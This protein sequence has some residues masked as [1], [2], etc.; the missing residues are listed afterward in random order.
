MLK[1]HYKNPDS[2]KPNQPWLP[3]VHG[4][5]I[6]E[7]K[8]ILLHRREDHGFWALPGGKIKLGESIVACL[9]RELLEETGLKVSIERLVG[10]YSAPD[11]L[12]SVKNAVYQPFL[13]VFLCQ[14]NKGALKQ[15]TESVNYTWLSPENIKTYRAFP[16]VKEIAYWIWDNKQKAFY[17]A[18]F[19]E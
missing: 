19:F 11:Y 2:P 15:T 12:L 5:I 3:S 17:D 18:V 10:I 9:K 8:H 16:L 6:N 7:N 4:A 1:I 14:V 13:V